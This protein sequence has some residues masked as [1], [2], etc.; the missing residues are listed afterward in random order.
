MTFSA[1]DN[2]DHV[3]TKW[4]LKLIQLDDEVLAYERAD[5]V[6]TRYMRVKK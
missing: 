4:E 1:S 6:T 3:G 5:G 2:S